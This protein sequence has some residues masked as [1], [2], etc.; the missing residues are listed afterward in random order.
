MHKLFGSFVRSAVM[1]EALD[2]SEVGHQKDRLTRQLT[3][4]LS[5]WSPGPSGPPTGGHRTDT[6]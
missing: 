4:F 6:W 1:T 2:R 5:P 3:R